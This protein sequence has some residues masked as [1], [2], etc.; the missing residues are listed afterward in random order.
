MLNSL[1]PIFLMKSIVDI[2]GALRII[3]TAL[4]KLK[5][6]KF[7]LFK[8]GGYKEYFIKYWNLFLCLYMV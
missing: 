6:C 5:N 1:Q 7:L 8:I 4:K 3:A 2:V